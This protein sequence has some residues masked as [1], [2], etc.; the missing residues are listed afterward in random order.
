MNLSLE[1]QRYLEDRLADILLEGK[2]KPDSVIKVDVRDDDII[3][4]PV[5]GD[6]DKG[7]EKASSK[8]I[9]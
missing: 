3:F 8:Q 5:S 9:V 7:L 2:I 1:I 6:E 4:I